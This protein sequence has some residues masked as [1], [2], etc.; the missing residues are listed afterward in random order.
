MFECLDNS[1]AKYH[2][3]YWYS[4]GGAREQ[5]NKRTRGQENKR[6]RGMDIKAMSM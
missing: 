3:H 2:D 6:T 1:E 5:E 4:D